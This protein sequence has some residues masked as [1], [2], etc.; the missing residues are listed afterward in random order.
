[1]RDE[2]RHGWRRLAG[3]GVPAA[4]SEE[5]VSRGERAHR[6]GVCCGQPGCLITNP[7]WT[8]RTPL[9]RL[10]GGP[11]GA[12][13]WSGGQAPLEDVASRLPWQRRC[14]DHGSTRGRNLRIKGNLGCVGPGIDGMIWLKYIGLA[15]LSRF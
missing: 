14:R 15:F 1:M 11:G 6:E 10:A 12:G 7:V 8:W 9:V 2:A 4:S 5:E 13:G 3:N